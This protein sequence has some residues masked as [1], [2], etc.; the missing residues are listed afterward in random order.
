VHSSQFS[1]LSSQ[2]ICRQSLPYVEPVT[3]GDDIVNLLDYQEFAK[4]WLIE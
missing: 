4:Y 1:V 2:K 3:K